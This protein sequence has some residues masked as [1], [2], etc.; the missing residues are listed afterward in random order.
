MAE[1]DHFLR[2]IKEH[3]ES[4]A[5][6]GANKTSLRN[7]WESVRSFLLVERRRMLAYGMKNGDKI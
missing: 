2:Y 6:Q 3:H 4:Y 5:K 1:K 7:M